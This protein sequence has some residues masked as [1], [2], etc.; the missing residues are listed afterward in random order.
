LVLPAQPT[1]VM[2]KIKNK[3]EKATPEKPF[4]RPSVAT[5]GSS[6]GKCLPAGFQTEWH[7][8]LLYP[9]RE[10]GKGVCTNHLHANE[11]LCLVMALMHMKECF[12]TSHRPLLSH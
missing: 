3:Q 5:R 12:Y 1:L 10:C 4:I 7:S 11:V 2:M 9:E 8:M 6:P